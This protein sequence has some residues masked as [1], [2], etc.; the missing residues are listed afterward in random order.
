MSRKHNFYAGPSTLPVPVLER[1]R[2]E[3][4]DTGGQGLSMIETSHRGGMY[5]RVHDEAIALLRELLGLPDTHRVL[6]LGGGATLQFAMVPMNFLGPEK[7]C[8]FL[9]SGVW[10]KKALAEARGRARCAWPSTGPPAGSRPSRRPR[11]CRFPL[12]RPTCI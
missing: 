10:A 4:V 2:D 9:L 1:I 3:I 5:E 6:F 8:D 11:V 12:I 7:S